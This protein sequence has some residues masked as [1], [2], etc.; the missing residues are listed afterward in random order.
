VQLPSHHVKEY[1][2]YTI[3]TRNAHFLIYMH[4][5]TLRIYFTCNP[6]PAQTHSPT[7]ETLSTSV[8]ASAAP[9]ASNFQPP[10]AMSRGRR[11]RTITGALTVRLGRHRYG[12]PQLNRQ[13]TFIKPVS[14]VLAVRKKPVWQR[15]FES[16]QQSIFEYSCWEGVFDHLIFLLLFRLRAGSPVRV[17]SA[18]LHDHME[19]IRTHVALDAVQERRAP[20]AAADQ[21]GA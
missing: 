11:S 13:G 3:Y 14:L 17:S 20:L 9:C 7:V 10:S 16:N 21:C 15:G 5:H 6:T 4:M 18:A 1:I 19:S 12:P 8:A 2:Q